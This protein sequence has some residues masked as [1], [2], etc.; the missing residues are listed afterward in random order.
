ME[1]EYEVVSAAGAAGEIILI[2]FIPLKL[3]ILL[4]FQPRKK[5]TSKNILKK[6]S[7]I[8]G[9]IK[10]INSSLHCKTK[11]KTTKHV[12]HTTTY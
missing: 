6:S 9:S 5:Y 3:L 1:F 12:T 10:K 4:H 11:L 7:Q 8:F 2:F